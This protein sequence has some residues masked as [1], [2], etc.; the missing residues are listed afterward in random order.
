MLFSN[1]KTRLPTPAEALPGRD[2]PICTPENHFVNGNPITPP[3]PINKEQA[4]FGM[5]CFW[6]AEKKFWQLQ[7]VYCTAVGYT[8]GYTPNP[9][10]DEL[11]TGLTGHT[12]VVKVVFDPQI[13]SY[14]QLLV[15]FWESHNP[16]QGMRQEVDIGT[17]YR[18]GIYTF[19]DQQT[20]AAQESKNHYQ[21][22]LTA[23]GF[24][25]ITTE[26][27]PAAEFYYAEN[28]HQQYL[29]KTPR[30]SACNIPLEQ[31]GRPPFAN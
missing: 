9:T 24:G 19:S 25:A 4:M 31:T 18:S 6:G 28:Y 10:Y 17:Q 12:E 14:L 27:Q 23:A 21:N 2:T 1:K 26:I 20:E 29:A 3:F 5:G 16:T 7:G 30:L 11:C 13:I 8:N 15:I 22:R